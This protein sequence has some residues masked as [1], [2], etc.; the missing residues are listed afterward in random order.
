MYKLE[1]ILEKCKKGN[2]EAAEQL[3]NTYSAKMFSI[4]IR[5]SR[6]RAEAEDNLQDGFI[7]IFESIHQYAGKG[8]FE[9][10]MKRIFINTSLEKYR[11]RNPIQLIEEYSDFEVEDISTDITIP[12]EL[13]MG[14]INELPEKY[15]MT[16][17]LYAIE[18]LSH[19]EIASMTGVTEGTSKSNLARARDILKRKINEYL[20]H[21]Q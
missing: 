18:E 17:N 11:K 20:K 3:Y 1:N 7:R 9:G 21:E 12:E 5:Y 10:W 16:F 13:L 8:S 19:K 2:R 4:C 6:N 15:K 14:F